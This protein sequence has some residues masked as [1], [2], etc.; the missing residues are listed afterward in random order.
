MSE[1][2][3]IFEITTLPE[4]ELTTK[5]RR[6][7]VEG[8]PV[9]PDTAPYIV[10]GANRK[11]LWVR[12]PSEKLNAGFRYGEELGDLSFSLVEA[13]EKEG[14]KN[15]WGNVQEL[16]FE[17]FESALAHYEYYEI[18]PVEL[19][20]SDQDPEITWDLKGVPTFRVPWLPSGYGILI[21]ENKGYFGSALFFPSDG[22]ALVIHNPSRGMVILREEIKNNEAV[23]EQSI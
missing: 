14:L 4:E 13:I 21:P 3:S 5:G 1:L 6:Y 11:L 23:A 8:I 19:F 12:K 18:S 9:S 15:E 20:L 10:S 22:V 7:M 17:G 16:S 2:K